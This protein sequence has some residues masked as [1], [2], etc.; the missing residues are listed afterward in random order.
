[1]IEENPSLQYLIKARKRQAS[2]TM[3]KIRDDQGITYTESFDITKVFTIQFRKKFSP[4][5]MDGESASLLMNCELRKITQEMNAVLE[6]PITIDELPNSIS[7]GKS[8]KAPG[9]DGLGLGF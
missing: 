3:K 6:D 4:I 5:R 2:S 1:M 8:Q 7:K 9:H